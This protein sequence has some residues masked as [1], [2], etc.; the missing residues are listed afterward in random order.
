MFIR[1]KGDFYYF[2]ERTISNFEEFPKPLQCCQCCISYSGRNMMLWLQI[3]PVALQPAA[4]AMC[5][6]NWYL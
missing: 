3:A 5:A 6:N 4:G 2:K 1:A